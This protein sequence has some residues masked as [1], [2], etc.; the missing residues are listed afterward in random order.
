MGFSI[1]GDV[2]ISS[3]SKEPKEAVEEKEV[4]TSTEESEEPTE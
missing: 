1:K 2:I 4:E 3:D